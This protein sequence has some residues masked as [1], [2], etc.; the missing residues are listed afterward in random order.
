MMFPA[1]PC[2]Y[3]GKPVPPYPPSSE[4]DRHVCKPEDRIRHL[5]RTAAR[6]QRQKEDNRLRLRWFLLGGLFATIANVA[7]MFL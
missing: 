2:A 3:C 7:R 4:E 1:I 5:E 6:L